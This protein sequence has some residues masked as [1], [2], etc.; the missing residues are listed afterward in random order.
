MAPRIFTRLFMRMT[1]EQGAK[2]DSEHPAR[3]LAETC[4]L[5]VVLRND[6]GALSR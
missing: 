6:K 1:V 4:V 5:A 3:R 2:P